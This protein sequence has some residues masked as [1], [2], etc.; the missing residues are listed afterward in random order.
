MPSS[1]GDRSSR[2]KRAGRS[3]T[4][5]GLIIA[6][7][8]ALHALLLMWVSLQTSE[9]WTLRTPEAEPDMVQFEFIPP[10]EPIPEPQNP[11]EKKAVVDPKPTPN[12]VTDAAPQPRPTPTPPQINPRPIQQMTVAQ[13]TPPT[14]VRPRQVSPLAPPAPMAPLPMAPA[15]P[16][17]GPPA[18]TAAP[19]NPGPSAPAGLGSRL[20]PFPGSGGAGLRSGLRR[21]AAAC[22]DAKALGLSKV[23][24]DWCDEQFGK[25]ATTAGQIAFPMAAGKRKALDG[26]AERQGAQRAWRE[27]GVPVGIDPKGGFGDPITDQKTGYP[28]V[29][30][31]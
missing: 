24:R 13:P 3:R 14:P 17:P 30:P 25:G 7:S 8:V 6:G 15:A 12:P 5:D 18:T 27:S 20:V 29:S 1:L 26:Q 22:A 16:Q 10:P 9:P 19:A 4:R 2:R 28:G 11:E 31:K 23:E 21:S